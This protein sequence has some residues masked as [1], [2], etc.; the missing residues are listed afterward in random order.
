MKKKQWHKFTFHCTELDNITGV[1]SA[2]MEFI[3]FSQCSTEVEDIKGAAM[4][5]KHCE[6]EIRYRVYNTVYC[7]KSQMAFRKNISPL[8]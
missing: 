5:K 6:Q 2:A 1:K 3:T 8:S 4:I 7:V